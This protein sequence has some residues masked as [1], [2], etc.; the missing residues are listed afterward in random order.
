MNDNITLSKDELRRLISDEMS[1]A[2]ADVITADELERALND[3]PTLRDVNTLIQSQVDAAITPAVQ[4]MQTTLQALTATISDRFA[5]LETL[6]ATIAEQSRNQGEW[7]RTMKHEQERQDE[8]QDDIKRSLAKLESRGVEQS[9][10]LDSQE[11][12]IFGDKTRP[13]TRSLFDHMSDGI[14]QLSLQVTTRFDE[15]ITQFQIEREQ[16]HQEMAQLQQTTDAICQEVQTNTQW[17]EA[18]QKVERFVVQSIPNAGK[19]I[20]AAAKDDFVVK[21]ATRIGLGGALAILAAVL[22]RLQ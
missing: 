11:R 2:M 9:A 8:E 20:V 7:M 1:K 17:R 16:S 6:I 18:R 21:W 12:A 5:K 15:V 10:K 19:R 14:N 13:G 3:R 22:E 4:E